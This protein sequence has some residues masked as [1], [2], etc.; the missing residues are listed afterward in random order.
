M[1][2]LVGMFKY[3]YRL[4]KLVV[5]VSGACFLLILVITGLGRLVEPTLK[6]QPDFTGLISIEY[7]CFWATVLVVYVVG[8]LIWIVYHLIKNDNE[9]TKK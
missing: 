5:T 9:E 4:S 7:T 1:K 2:F 8:S 6:A 3:L